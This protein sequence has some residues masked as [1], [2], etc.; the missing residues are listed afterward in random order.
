MASERLGC[1]PCEGAGELG[2]E[3]RADADD[4]GQHHHLDARRDDI[5]ENA[6][7]QERGLAPQRERHQ[8]EARQ[9]GELEFQ[10]GDEEL[11]GENEERQHHDEPRAHQNENGHKVGEDGGEADERAGLLKQRPCRLK[12]RARELARTQEIGGRQ[13]AVSSRAIPASRTN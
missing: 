6:L 8:H 7:G 11:N 3:R 5:A 2:E 9:C 4:D 13:S 10:D 12:A 1:W